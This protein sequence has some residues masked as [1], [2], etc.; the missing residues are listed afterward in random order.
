MSDSGKN[1][2]LVLI[3]DDDDGVREFLSFVIAREGFRAEIAVDG[4]DGYQKAESCKPDL[5]LLDLMMPRLGGFEV[6]RRLQT[7][8]LS[9][10]PIVVITGRYTDRAMAEMIRQESNV[11]DFLEKPI[12]SNVRGATLARLLKPRA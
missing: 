3:I 1:A 2:K 4:E 5:I 6:L 10:I 9:K 12:K 7:G 8:E 11:A